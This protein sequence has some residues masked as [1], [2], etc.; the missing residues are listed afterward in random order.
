M[1]KTEHL[2]IG[3]VLGGIAGL[4]PSLFFG[5]KPLGEKLNSYKAIVVECEKELPRNQSCELVA[6]PKEQGKYPI[7]TLVNP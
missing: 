7:K 1:G 4:F 6:K 3:I 5:V 2:V